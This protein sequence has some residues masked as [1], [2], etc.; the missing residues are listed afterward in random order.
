MIDAMIPVHISGVWIGGMKSDLT[1]TG[2]RHE[3]RRHSNSNTS[4]KCG[5]AMKYI[6]QNDDGL[7]EIVDRLGFPA[8][9]EGIEEAREQV[10]VVRMM[11][12]GLRGEVSGREKAALLSAVGGIVDAL[13]GN[14][15]FVAELVAQRAPELTETLFGDRQRDAA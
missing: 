12:R 5:S 14:R 11:V 13:D 9:F 15:T 1:C 3:D 4:R 7:S 8:L 6:E 2:A 10:E